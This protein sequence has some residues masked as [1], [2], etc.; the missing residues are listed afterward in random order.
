MDSGKNSSR[1]YKIIIA[2]LCVISIAGWVTLLIPKN[3]SRVCKAPGCTYY[4]E[5]DSDYCYKHRKFNSTGYTEP[6]STEP[7]SRETVG[8]S[9]PQ[10]SSVA[11]LNN[12]SGKGDTSSQEKTTRDYSDLINDP[13]DYDNPDDYADDAWGV[14][15]D[16]WDDAYDFWENY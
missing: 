12:N 15:F 7:D 3:E 10:E 16:D 14:D 2:L 5:A 4:R 1:F 13:A 6:R 11:A 8:G 9:E